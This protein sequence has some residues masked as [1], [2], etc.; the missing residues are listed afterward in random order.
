MKLSSYYSHELNMI[1][2]Y[3]GHV[4]LIFIRVL[5]FWQLC[6]QSVLSLQLLLQFAV[7]FS[8]TFQLVFPWPEED[9]LIPRSD[10]TAFYQSYR[11]LSVLAILSTEVLVSAISPTF[12][13]EFQFEFSSYCFHNLRS[14]LFLPELWPFG[15]ISTVN[16]VPTNPLAVFS[17]F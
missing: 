8:K 17:G 10:L 13:K 5:D 2:F 1:I 14:C 7:D 12:L 3:Q 9:H 15:N 11:P 4:L 16:L 6:Q